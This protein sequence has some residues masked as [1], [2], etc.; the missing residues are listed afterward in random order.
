MKATST[1]HGS[2]FW[3]PNTCVPALFRM[4]TMPFGSK[5]S[6]SAFLRVSQAIKILGIVYGGL[7]W[8]AFYD[9]FVCIRKR[10]TE[11]QTDHMVRLLFNSLGW[12][13]SEDEDKDKPFAEFFHALGVEFGL[14]GSRLS[15]WLV[16]S[17]QYRLS[18]M[19]DQRQGA[20]HSGQRCS[21]TICS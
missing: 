8:S 7:I 17:W 1:L 9:D 12:V 14:S 5:A 3:D 2:Q 19:G 16:H 6:V 15:T 21:G 13:L 10:G 4:D 20:V 11:V 18:K